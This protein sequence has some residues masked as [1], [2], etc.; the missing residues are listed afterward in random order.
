MNEVMRFE[1]PAECDVVQ[2]GTEDQRLGGTELQN[3]TK[4]C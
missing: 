4:N 1:V 2:S 3:K